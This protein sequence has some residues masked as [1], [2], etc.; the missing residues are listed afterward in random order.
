MNSQVGGGKI[1][2]YENIGGI[3]KSNEWYTPPEVFEKLNTTFDLD[4]SAPK[5]GVPWIPAKNHF[6]IELDGL[7]QQWN[8]FVWCNPP[9]GKETANW[10]KK[11]VEHR[12]GI[13]LVFARTDTKWFHEYAIKSDILC[14]IKS[15][16]AFIKDNQQANCGSTGSLLI[17]C[18]EKAIQV[19]KNTDL[20]FVVLLKNTGEIK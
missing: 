5:G 1:A 13:A 12:N 11:F 3:V 7:K 4:V 18:G 17:G 8:G 19:I 14:F 10:L 6:H 15:R 2:F 20:G 16:I 9:Y